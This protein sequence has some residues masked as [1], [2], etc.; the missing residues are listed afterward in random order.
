MVGWGA[1]SADVLPSEAG[2]PQRGEGG[3]ALYATPTPSSS[4]P[5]GQALGVATGEGV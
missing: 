2:W 4:S 3:W 1:V 5:V